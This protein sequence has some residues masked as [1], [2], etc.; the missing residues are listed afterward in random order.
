MVVYPAAPFVTSQQTAASEIGC[1]LRAI[2]SFHHRNQTA[3]RRDFIHAREGAKFFHSRTERKVSQESQLN[4]DSVIEKTGSFK[5]IYRSNRGREI[6]LLHEQISESSFMSLFAICLS[7]PV[8]T[9]FTLLP[10]GLHSFT[11]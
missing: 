2:E 9:L 8:F 10:F 4:G 11:S 1:R 7:C 3:V 6:S 5:R